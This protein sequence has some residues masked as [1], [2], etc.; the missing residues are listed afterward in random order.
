[1]NRAKHSILALLMM[2]I[3]MTSC[4]DNLMDMESDIISTNSLDPMTRSTSDS[5][6]EEDATILE[7]TYELKRLKEISDQL[8]SSKRKAVA[9]TTDDFFY[10]NIF[11]IN[12]MPI[13]GNVSLLHYNR[14]LKYV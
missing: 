3:F 13:T 1:M 8:K 6:C 9:A 11:A 12:E 5:I 4:N 10:S 14:S 7:E 2:A